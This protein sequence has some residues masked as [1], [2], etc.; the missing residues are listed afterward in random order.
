MKK[1]IIALLAFILAIEVLLQ[2]SINLLDGLS[3]GGIDE[4]VEQKPQVKP[5]RFSWILLLIIV[6]FLEPVLKRF[7]L[8]K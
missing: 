2:G 5:L 6:L 3:S 4:T 8:A 1:Y 7:R